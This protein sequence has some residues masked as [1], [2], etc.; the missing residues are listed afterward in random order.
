MIVERQMALKLRFTPLAMDQSDTNPPENDLGPSIDQE[1]LI[2]AIRESGYPLQVAV[3]EKLQGAF[4]VT[5]EWGY[6]DRDTGKHRTLDVFAFKILPGGAVQPYFVLLVECKRSVH[7]Y[8]FFQNAILRH[9]PDYPTVVGLN[10]QSTLLQAD[11]RSQ[12]VTPA[13]I[14]GL[15][16]LPFIQ[17]GPAL[18]SAFARAIA[19]GKKFELSGSEPF[20]SL[21]L[22]LVK[23]VDH[24]KRLYQHS[25][26]NSPLQPTL[27]LCASVVDAP[28][29]LATGPQESLDFQLTP[30]VRVPRQEDH[31]SGSGYKRVQYGIDVIHIA[32]LDTYI[33]KHLV[34]FV[35]QFGEHAHQQATVLN[36]GGVVTDL[37]NW[38]WNEIKPAGR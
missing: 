34:P 7:P 11:N 2:R 32:F 18:C 9:L 1:N 16:E 23:A 20:N 26:A 31:E 25:P 12:E 3:A 10:Y 4:G 28:L 36:Q 35:T 38:R 33:S 22:P 24:A 21:V 6:V 14:L 37:K 8:I 5:E 13:A 15:A 27:I 30:W 19:N 29:V 17:S